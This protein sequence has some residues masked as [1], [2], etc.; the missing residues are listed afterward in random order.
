MTTVLLG[1][2]SKTDLRCLPKA[3]KD[4]DISNAIKID[5]DPKVGPDILADLRID[6]LPFP[7]NSI[8]VIIDT[9]GGAAFTWYKR[10]HFWKEIIRILSPNGKFYGLQINISRKSFKIP[11][12][13]KLTV[14]KN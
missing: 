2:G 13:F 14:L 12:V 10:Y 5:A 9:G 3:A 6:N 7:D 4:I 8:R 11:K 1:H